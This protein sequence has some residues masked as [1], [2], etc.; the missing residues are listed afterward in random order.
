[1]VARHQGLL[2]FFGYS[3]QCVVMKC[4]PPAAKSSVCYCRCGVHVCCSFADGCA[5]V[6][7]IQMQLCF[8]MFLSLNPG[9]S[10][11]ATKSSCSKAKGNPPVLLSDWVNY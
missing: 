11:T 7:A 4:S 9:N 1:M 6:A 3:P 8:A 2:L 10:S 5:V